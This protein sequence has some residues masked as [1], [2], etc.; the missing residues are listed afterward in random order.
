MALVI[1]F[2]T[3]EQR[4]PRSIACEP[5]KNFSDLALLRQMFA[6]LFK[7]GVMPSPEARLSDVAGAG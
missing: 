4:L 3:G 2:L 7:G 5:P 1:W 6:L